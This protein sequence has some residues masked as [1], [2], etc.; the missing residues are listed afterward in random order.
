MRNYKEICAAF[1][2]QN[3]NNEKINDISLFGW[4]HYIDDN[5]YSTVGVV[6]TAQIL[7]LIKQNELPIS[8][9]CRPMFFSLIKMQNTDGGWSYRSNL[10]CSATEPT[11]LCI[12]ALLMW[13]EFIGEKE[14]QCIE[15]G[16]EWLLVNK[17]RECIWGPI[18]NTD[19]KGYT[20]FTCV[21]LLTLNFIR[22]EKRKCFDEQTISKINKIIDAATKYI[23]EAFSDRP[24]YGWGK[25]FR[26]TPM[27]FHTAFIVFTLLQ[28]N[29]EY[30]KKYSILKSIE[31]LKCQGDNEQ[32]IYR[33]G[34]HDIYQ[35]GSERLSY[36]HSVDVYITLALL[37]VGDIEIRN[38]PFVANNIDK[39]YECAQNANWE[40]QEYVTC[41]RMY[42]I[43]TFINY[44]EK[45]LCKDGIMNEMKKYKVALTF[46]GESRHTVDK[47]AH[48]L[49]DF[50]D[51]NEI[52]YD[53]F[54]KAEFARPQL[55]I[56]LQKLYHDDSELIVVFICDN[57][58]LKEWCGVEWRA[59]RDIL[60]NFE[61]EKIMYV[62]L[63]GDKIREITLPGF[64]GTEDGYIDGKTITE[65]EIAELI[66]ERYNIKGNY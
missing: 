18:N 31:V 55:D 25:E 30:L 58:S 1:I 24:I 66:V 47:V 49:L 14:K 27:Q 44:Y 51:K 61:Y 16:V 34:L 48:S 50:F 37:S 12:H 39:I 59:I 60:N 28:I 23:F 64:Y 4:Y 21:A 53:N 57:Y 45:N 33:Q 54:H 8:F 38:M 7:I 17:N 65:K 11:A 41:W 36:I 20:Y 63:C 32:G 2:E 43:L 56:Y 52:L 42:D 13:E 15:K 40:Y 35:S 10:K 29:S 26:E 19:N 6:A 62:S 9:D 5:S 46:A 22:Q 3:I